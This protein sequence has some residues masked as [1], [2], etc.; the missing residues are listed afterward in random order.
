MVP[1]ITLGQQAVRE[2]EMYITGLGIYI[3]HVFGAEIGELM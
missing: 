2:T 3:G 1:W